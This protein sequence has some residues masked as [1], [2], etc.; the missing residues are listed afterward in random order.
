M[1]DYAGMVYVESKTK[2]SVP[3]EP[4]VVSNKNQ[5]GQRHDQLYRCSLRQK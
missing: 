3:I 2:L 4:G 1:I 5:T